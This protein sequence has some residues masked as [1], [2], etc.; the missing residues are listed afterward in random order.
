MRTKSLTLNLI[1]FLQVP[2]RADTSRDQTMATTLFAELCDELLEDST[3]ALAGLLFA[4]TSLTFVVQMKF[5]KLMKSHGTIR[6]CT[7]PEFPF[8]WSL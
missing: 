6:K 3:Q 5:S 8:V 1:V 4:S 2:V 7:L